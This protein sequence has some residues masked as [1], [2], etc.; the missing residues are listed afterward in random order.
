[1]AAAWGRHGVGLGQL[2]A[3]AAYLGQA[4]LPVSELWRPEHRSDD[5]AAKLQRMLPRIGRHPMQQLGSIRQLNPEE[6]FLIW[7]AAGQRGAC[8]QHLEGDAQLGT[9]RLESRGSGVGKRGW[10]GHHLQ[11]R[12]GVGG[13]FWGGGHC[14]KPLCATTLTACR[15]ICMSMYMQHPHTD[16]YACHVHGH[17]LPADA[18]ACLRRWAC[19]AC[20]CTCM[21][22]YMD[23]CCLQM[24]VLKLRVAHETLKDDN[25]LTTLCETTTQRTQVRL[26][27][28]QDLGWWVWASEWAS[29]R[30]TVRHTGVSEAARGFQ[31]LQRSRATV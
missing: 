16:A 31:G 20:R 28:G 10:Q 18:H 7:Q 8:R 3:V 21:S 9:M 30:I 14:P 13:F 23:M 4:Q 17:V 25:V 22:T 29:A 11:A 5:L 24:H 26:H 6:R 2:R 27:L 15:C 1:M 12:E 19:A